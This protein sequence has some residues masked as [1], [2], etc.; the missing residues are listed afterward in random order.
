[1]TSTKDKL[2]GMKLT[3]LELIEDLEALETSER[4]E[5]D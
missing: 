2:Y 1:M 3:V 4:D 5:E